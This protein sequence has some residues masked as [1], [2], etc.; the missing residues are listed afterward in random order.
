MT[1]TLMGFLKQ[2]ELWIGIIGALIGGFLTL[3][4]QWRQIKYNEAQSRQQKKDT[5]L[6]KLKSV[7]SKILKIYSNL[8]SINF[9]IQKKVKNS[10]YIKHNSPQHWQWIRP[11]FP[12]PQC[13]YFNADELSPLIDKKFLKIFNE[14]SNIDNIHNFYIKLIENYTK[15]RS[16]IQSEQTIIGAEIINGDLKT[17]SIIQKDKYLQL[18]PKITEANMMIDELISSIS[19]DIGEIKLLL[20]EIGKIL[21]DEYNEDIKFSLKIT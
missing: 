13:I 19:N 10:E 1:D 15:L 3:Y 9:E 18:T 14:L 8:H 4:T 6:S 12:I 2:K 21:K 17:E 5:D 11:P 16:E 7:V 20:N